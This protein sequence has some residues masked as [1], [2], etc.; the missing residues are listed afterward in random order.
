MMKNG[1]MTAFLLSFLVVFSLSLF[2]GD[3]EMTGMVRSYTG[4]RPAEGDVPVTEQTVDLTLQGYG[5][6]TRITVNPYVYLNPDV[7][8]EI[9][10]REAYIDIFFPFVDLRIG[11]QTVV[12]GE[13]EGAFI[14]DVVSPQDMRSF[15]L[16]DF[17]E[18]RMGVTA[19]K[20]DWYA[21]PFTVETVW[22]PRFVPAGRPDVGSI[23][24]TDEMTLLSGASLPDG[25]LENS[26]AFGKIS[27]FGSALNAEFMAGYAWDDQPVLTG[28]LSSPDAVYR[29]YA[30]TGGSLST[31]L[32]P[33]VLRSEGA[34]YLDR[35]FTALTGPGTI[36]ALEHNQI[37]G[38]GGLDWSFLGTDMSVQYIAD[39][40]I[41][42]DDRIQRDEYSQTATFRVR[43]SYL[44]DTLDLELFV[45]LGIDPWD[46]LLR[47]SMTYSIEDGV[48]LKAG[49]EIFVG[50]ED[51]RFGTYRDNTMLFASISWYF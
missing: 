40:I 19:L 3:I 8:P 35:D 30:L 18:V 5:E 11:K 48:D 9:G 16:A 2:A 6:L 51:G 10:V 45:Y 22:L 32:G 49:A 26:E 21:G 24:Y 25:R 17:R 37:H 50:D 36:E 27:Y 33:L 29:R 23:W 41:D 1:K 7:D 44:S 14:T 28:S 12:W 15:I 20:A 31:T 39:Y 34:V 13:A 47:P 38:L 46:A 4:A 43:D 42:Y